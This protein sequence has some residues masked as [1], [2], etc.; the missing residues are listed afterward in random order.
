MKIHAAVAAAGVRAIVSRG[1][2]GLGELPAGAAQPADVLSIGSVPHDWLF[3]RCSGV[4]TCFSPEPLPTIGTA[5]SVLSCGLFCC[6]VAPCRHDWL[7]PRCSGVETCFYPE[8]LPTIGT[9]MSVLSCG[10]FRCPVAPCRHDW[11]FPRCSSVCGDF[12][13]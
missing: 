4:E 8:P 5:M 12:L 7:F 9:A 1:W 6:P 11:L 13:R 3:P 10:L 2:G